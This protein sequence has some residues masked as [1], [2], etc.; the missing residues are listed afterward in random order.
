MRCRK[1]LFLIDKKLSRFHDL[2]F[3]GMSSRRE[4]QIYIKNDST[5]IDSGKNESNTT[6]F[7][8]DVHSALKAGFAITFVITK[9]EYEN[10]VTRCGIGEGD[11]QIFRFPDLMRLD[12][13]CIRPKEMFRIMISERER[14]LELNIEIFKA[15]GPNGKYLR[16]PSNSHLP[17]GEVARTVLKKRIINKEP[18]WAVEVLINMPE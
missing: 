16:L 17:S 14:P 1:E 3:V 15:K 12:L 6:P 13:D 11:F 18:M 10:D 5:Y 4:T 8:L 9:Q 2:S 7:L